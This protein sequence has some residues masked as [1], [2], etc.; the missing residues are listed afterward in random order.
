MERRLQAGRLTQGVLDQQDAWRPDHLDQG[1]PQ[2]VFG[3]GIPHR[4]DHDADGMKPWLVGGD[5]LGDRG[6]AHRQRGLTRRDQGA[7]EIPPNGGGGGGIADDHRLGGRLLPLGQGA[8][9]IE[10][11][12]IHLGAERHGERNDVDPDTLRAEQAGLG[13]GIPEVRAAV[14][15][16]HDVAAAVLGQEGAAQLQRGGEIGELR[17]RLALELAELRSI[18]DADLDLGIPA[19]AEHAGAIL[20]LPLLQDA[21]HGGGLTVAG[22]LHAGGEVGGHQQRLVAG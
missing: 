1:L 8:R 14:A 11:V 10:P 22:A 9:R 12:D 13:H 5:Q 2:V 19:E 18:A 20:A 3:V 17:V 7:I 6:L 15:D 16:H 21:A 4:V